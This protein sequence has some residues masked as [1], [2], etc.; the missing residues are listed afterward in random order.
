MSGFLFSVLW[1]GWQMFCGRNTRGTHNFYSVRSNCS[2]RRQLQVG[3]LSE[4]FYK[5]RQEKNWLNL[6]VIK[7]NIGA[8]LRVPEQRG[9]AIST[10][11]LFPT[12][13]TACKGMK[14][15]SWGL[16]F[17]WWF[18]KRCCGGRVKMWHDN[19]LWLPKRLR[20][21][22]IWQTHTASFNSPPFKKKKNPHLS[23]E[24]DSSQVQQQP[25]KLCTSGLKAWFIAE[26]EVFLGIK[27]KN[28]KH[29][30]QSRV[31]VLCFKN[32]NRAIKEIYWSRTADNPS[33]SLTKFN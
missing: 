10:L 13:L 5:S 1:D 9:V 17:L 11:V 12:R 14:L 30:Q 27:E 29:R 16:Y 24:G 3:G 19:C 21:S 26:S 6:M 8:L 23:L 31:N 15:H 2:K 7:F 4:D 18:S 20:P 22:A 32:D 25:V 33:L 28:N